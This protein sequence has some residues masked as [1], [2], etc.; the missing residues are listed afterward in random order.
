MV[1]ISLFISNCVSFQ[2]DVYL[3]LALLRLRLV[4]GSGTPN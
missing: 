3:N 2:P 4:M 1:Y